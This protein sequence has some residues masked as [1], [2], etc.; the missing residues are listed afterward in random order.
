MGHSLVLAG[1]ADNS[2]EVGVAALARRIARWT[3]NGELHTTAS[4]S[5]FNREYN[6]QFG[7]PPL[8][9]ITKLRQMSAA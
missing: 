8:R 7:A 2:L 5:Q 4:P 3:E 1:S 9:D 6:R